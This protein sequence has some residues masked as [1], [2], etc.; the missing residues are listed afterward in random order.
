MF[1]RRFSLRNQIPIYEVNVEFNIETILYRFDI[2]AHYVMFFLTFII[3]VF[4]LPSDIA[5]TLYSIIKPF[6][7][8]EISCI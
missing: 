8:F 3:I 2:F 5:S 6:D 7:V 4:T 1:T